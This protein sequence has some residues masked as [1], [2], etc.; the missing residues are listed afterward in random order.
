M[1]I[2]LVNQSLM[3]AK[4]INRLEVKKERSWLEK[5]R[6]TQRDR[7][8]SDKKSRSSSVKRM[9]QHQLTVKYQRQERDSLQR[10]S[11]HL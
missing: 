10:K 3:L 5:E 7:E 8:Y 1:N 6:K 9:E 11:L 4:Q 2:S